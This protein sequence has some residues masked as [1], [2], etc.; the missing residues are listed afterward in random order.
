M[1]T[2]RKLLIGIGA[3][4]AGTVVMVVAFGSSGKNDSFLPQNEFKL[5]PWI[6]IKV[7][8]I[9]VSINKAVLYVVLASLLTCATMIYIARRMQQ[10]PNKVQTAV[11]ALFSLMRDNIT[12]GNMDDEMARKW[13][14]FVGALF[15][16]IMF[17]NL[18]GYIP[19]P[20]STEHEITVFGLRVPAFALYSATA[21]LSIPLVLALIV[22]VSYT[23]EG[24]RKKGPIGYLKGLIPAGVHGAMVLLI[25]PLEL[26]SQFMRLISLSVRLFANILA[27]HLMILFFGGALA[28]LLGAAAIAWFTLPLAIAIF[29]FEAVLIAGLQAFIFATLTA[30]YLGGAV[31]DH[32]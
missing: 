15:L 31:A 19:L 3:W 21:N 17:S 11:E 1:S 12:R 14:P 26:L 8:G 5:D 10:R 4:L 7:A 30:I 20:T 23:A 29:M 16:F 27:G 25:F 13:F 28:V 9:D 2:K 24:V 32:H 18:I 6:P 22:V